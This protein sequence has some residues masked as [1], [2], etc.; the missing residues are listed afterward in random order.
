MHPAVRDDRLWFQKHQTASVRFRQAIQ[1]E[2]SPLLKH[3]EEPPIF[4]PSCTTPSSPLTWVAVIDLM[5]LCAPKQ[6][7]STE[8]TLRL[9]IRIPAIRSRA[10]Q[11]AAAEE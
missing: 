7:V 4:R 5:R 9:R 11:E 8:P 3:G 6:R 1:S 2:F 10:N